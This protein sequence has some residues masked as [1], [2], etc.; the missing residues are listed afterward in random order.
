MYDIF[1]IFGLYQCENII[2]NNVKTLYEYIWL[3]NRYDYACYRYTV[4]TV[5]K[6]LSIEEKT[7]QIVHKHVGPQLRR[8]T[9]EKS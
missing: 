5:E 2:I 7:I 1:F 9:D 6:C 8:R 3:V 4:H